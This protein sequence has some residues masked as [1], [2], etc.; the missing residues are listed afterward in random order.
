MTT[1]NCNLLALDLVVDFGMPVYIYVQGWTRLST[2]R[3]LIRLANN[4]HI[5]N[6]RHGNEKE[7]DLCERG[8]EPVIGQYS[9]V[10]G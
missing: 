7:Q 2:I 9:L 6:G 8:Q 4:G 10:D 1:L 3:Y 5:V